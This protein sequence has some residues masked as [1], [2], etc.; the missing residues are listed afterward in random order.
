MQAT[1][2]DVDKVDVVTQYP[3]TDDQKNTLLV[4]L[5][6]ITDVPIKDVQEMVVP[7]LV[8]LSVQIKEARR[9]KRDELEEKKGGRR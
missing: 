5:S 4:E 6:K 1:V 3:K 8:A 7:E 2:F 9:K